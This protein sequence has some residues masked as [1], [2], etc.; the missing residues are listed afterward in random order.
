MKINVWSLSII[1]LAVTAMNVNSFATD[2]TTS[3]VVKKS[4]RVTP[5]GAPYLEI[6]GVRNLHG[7]PVEYVIG[8]PQNTTQNTPLIMT[9]HGYNDDGE[10]R[11]DDETEPEDWMDQIQWKAIEL[12]YAFAGSE[13]TS[14][15]GG[16][17]P[18]LWELN[19]GAGPDYN[20]VPFY[21][22]IEATYD[23]AVYTRN[24]YQ[25]GG[26]GLGSASRVFIA[27]HSMG[28]TIACL[29]TI[30]NFGGFGIPNGFYRGVLNLAGNTDS[31]TLYDYFV[32]AIFALGED[33]L[34]LFDRDSDS[35][36]FMEWAGMAGAVGKVI[37]DM[38]QATGFPT[39]YTE[40]GF[41]RYEWR[42]ISPI[43]HLNVGKHRIGPYIPSHIPFITVAGTED[44]YTPDGWDITDRTWGPTPP[45][46]NYR[47]GET[48]DEYLG[49]NGNPH[50]FYRYKCDH[51]TVETH[52]RKHLQE[53][54]EWTFDLEPVNIL[55]SEP[56][57]PF[58]TE[59]LPNYPNPFCSE[60][61]IPFKL[62]T[63]ATV[64]IRI[65][66]ISG[67]LVRNWNIGYVNAGDYT[68]KG[69]AVYW[70]GTDN[71]G[72]RVSSG[73]YLYTLKADDFTATGKMV[74]LGREYCRDAFR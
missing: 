30:P 65:F 8:L 73:V 50:R 2:T 9:C 35:D 66:T 22:G 51:G 16:D 12:G 34:R 36:S 31:V 74:L 37:F 52:G 63:D 59:L 21:E 29:S 42:D 5:K 71:Y 19:F 41:I 40:D 3:G 56:S 1:F 58:R 70:N 49:R 6:Q 60:T 44:V 27:G 47:I 46:V 53:L 68:T 26:D 62:S 4:D 69:K 13:Y 45:D 23:L 20:G 48:F 17:W 57:I 64:T 18:T 61:W 32:T 33:S 14:G 11:S 24:T 72:A 15:G 43:Y 54:V 7:E 39:P 67:T 25:V 55:M 28:G 10:D 38:R